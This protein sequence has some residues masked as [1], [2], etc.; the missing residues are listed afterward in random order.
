MM[1]LLLALSLLPMPAAAETTL[2]VMTFNIWG[3]GANEE[4]GIE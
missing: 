1:R 4:K 2:R 3:G